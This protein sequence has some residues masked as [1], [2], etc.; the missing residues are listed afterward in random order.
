LRRLTGASFLVRGRRAPDLDR[1]SRRRAR[2][3]GRT[4]GRNRPFSALQ[5]RP[6][7]RTGSTRK[8]SSSGALGTFSTLIKPHSRKALAAALLGGIVTRPP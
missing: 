2:R 7:E 4:R 3:P 6:C 1:S 8:R 5:E